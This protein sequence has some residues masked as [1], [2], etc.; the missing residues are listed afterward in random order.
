MPRCGDCG[1]P[2][3][4]GSA[5]CYACH[6]KRLAACWAA[7]KAPC[8]RGCG[9]PRAKYPRGLCYRCYTTPAVR[10]RH[11]RVQAGTAR[12]GAGL[13]APA[14][15]SEPEPTDAPPGSA[16]KVEA[17]AERARLG[18]TLYHPK[19]RR[20]R[21]DAPGWEAGALV[22]QRFHAAEGGRVPRGRRTG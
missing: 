20:D 2:A 4:H 19:D 13:A 3:S 5:R 17:L 7:L 16:A 11:A 8:C 14:A 12:L 9:N 21:D 1:G 15:G 10:A 6:A 22:P 18:Q